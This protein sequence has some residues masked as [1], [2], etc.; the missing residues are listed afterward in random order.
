MYITYM[1]TQIHSILHDTQIYVYIQTYKHIRNVVY[2]SMGVVFALTNNQAVFGND[3]LRS[4]M[5][6]RTI[7]RLANRTMYLF[8]ISVY[9]CTLVCVSFGCVI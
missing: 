4:T 5:K 7:D 3:D 1:C 2:I 9:L 8:A 6:I